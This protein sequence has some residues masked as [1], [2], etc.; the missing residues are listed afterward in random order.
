VWL[1]RRGSIGFTPLGGSGRSAP[2]LIVHQKRV[3]VVVGGG[4]QNLW[5]RDTAVG[6]D[7]GWLPLGPPGT[8]CFGQAAIVAGGDLHVG[9]RGEDRALYVGT[10]TM[11]ATGLPARIKR[12]SRLGGETDYAPAVAAVDGEVTWFVTGRNLAPEDNLYR[13]G[14]D[15]WQRM[16]IR[17]AGP[18]GAGWSRSVAYVGC[19][20]ASGGLRYATGRFSSFGGADGKFTGAP[21]FAVNDDGSATAVVT[22]LDSAFYR[23][24]LAPD[25]P[26]DSGWA[27]L[28]GRFLDGASAAA[29]P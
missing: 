1:V 4:D 15:G 14:P 8:R 10:T 28:G 11:R 29:E 3:L 23:R 7:G 22:G 13:R 20:D 17:C 24:R 9:C 6:A 16:P 5:I 21:G 2:T 18:P 26:A 25:A 27:Q 12:W 19:R